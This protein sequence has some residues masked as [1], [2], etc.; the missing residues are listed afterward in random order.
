MLKLYYAYPPHL[1]SSCL[2]LLFFIAK[3]VSFK[4]RCSDR[5]RQK[6][7]GIAKKPE[8]QRWTTKLNLIDP[9]TIWRKEMTNLARCPAVYGRLRSLRS[10]RLV[11]PRNLPAAR[12][13]VRVCGWNRLDEVCSRGK[14]K[15]YIYHLSMEASQALFLLLHCRRH[16]QNSTDCASGARRARLIWQPTHAQ[17]LPQQWMPSAGVWENRIT[18]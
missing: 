3:Y 4:C 10:L 2:L 14:D 11:Y 17:N 18:Q 6:T 7:T 15:W 13:S 12:K 5:G 16:V 1:L 8:G 9:G